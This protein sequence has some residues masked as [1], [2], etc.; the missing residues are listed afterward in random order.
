MDRV[1]R[2]LVRD[3]KA[4]ILQEKGGMNGKG[5]KGAVGKDLLTVLGKL[6]D[7]V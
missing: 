7:S 4:A 6:L 2:Q 3:K 1:G 5:D